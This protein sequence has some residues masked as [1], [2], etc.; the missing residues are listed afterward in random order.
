MKVLHYLFGLPP[1]RSGGLVKYVLDLAKGQRDQGL[2]VCLMIPGEIHK[3]K[4][5]IIKK[6]KYKDFVC[7]HVINPVLVSCGERIYDMTV[8]CESG[9]PDVYIKFL[10]SVSPD[11]IHIHS[12][13]GLHLAF[14]QAAEQLRIP[15]IYTTHDYYGL[16]PKYSNYAENGVECRADGSMCGLCM[17]SPTEISKLQVQHMQYYAWLKKNTVVNWIEYSKK[18]LRLKWWLRRRKKKYSTAMSNGNAD[19]MSDSFKTLKSHYKNM[20]SYITFFHFNSS[21]TEKIYKMSLENIEGKVINI[22]NH[23]V[24]DNR[25]IHSYEKKLKL[26][27]LSN[28]QTI[29]GYEV[30]MD[31]LDRLYNDGFHEFEC[32]IYCN[33]DRFGVPYFKTHKPYTEKSMGKIFDNMDVLIVPSL[34]KETFG[35][36]ALE[37]ISYGVPVIFSENVGA[38]DIFD[39]NKGIGI[40]VDIEND[41]NALYDAIKKVYENRQLLVQMNQNIMET[42]IELCYDVHVKEIIDLYESISDS[43]QKKVVGK[44]A[45]G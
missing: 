36:V 2:D 42:K 24:A 40:K 32:H 5:T 37:A 3:D 13:M 17:G 9:N 30:L 6:R 41:K 39:K 38:K 15:M 26:A 14:L 7:Y 34:W 20:F 8:L 28:R 25:K 33:E 23:S 27:Y 12:L 21:Q 19:I 18:L 44:W 45:K 43:F 4:K 16:C 31:T 29:K 11:I 22:S 10:Q 1:V 35:M